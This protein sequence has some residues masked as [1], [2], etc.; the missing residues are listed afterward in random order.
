MLVVSL[1]NGGQAERQRARVYDRRPEH[2]LARYGPM[3]PLSLVFRPSRR[4]DENGVE[5]GGVMP[6]RRR[7][8]RAGSEGSKQLNSG[9]LCVNADIEWKSVMV[10]HK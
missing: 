7:A 6:S 9:E 4:H 3:K 1:L 8:Q 2:A 10:V 5:A